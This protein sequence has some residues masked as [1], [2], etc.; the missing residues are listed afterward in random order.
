VNHLPK[1]VAVGYI[2]ETIP[3]T[4]LV[5]KTVYELQAAFTQS[6][7]TRELYVHICAYTVS[8]K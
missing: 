8:Q 1:I 5:C 4:T 6:I 7:V 3:C 2:C